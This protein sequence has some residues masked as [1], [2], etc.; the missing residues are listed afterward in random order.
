[1]AAI[2]APAADET[3]QIRDLEVVVDGD[4]YV[5]S[6]RLPDGLTPERI[7]AI[8]AGLETAIAYRLNLYR[9]RTGLPN[10]TVTRQRIECTVRHDALTRQ[11]TLTRRIDGELQ[12]TKVTSDEA[13]MREFMTELRRV[14]VATVDEL[15]AGEAYYL[16]ARSDLGL[17][18]RFYLIPWRERTPWAQVPVEV[19][20][21]D[22]GEAGSDGAAP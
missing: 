12:E 13:Q 16:R 11:Y 1:M 7:E 8:D 6:A 4:V 22:G 5:A 14:P 9:E 17:V 15:R 10:Q 20:E 19:R 18:W 21:A 2:A 3:L